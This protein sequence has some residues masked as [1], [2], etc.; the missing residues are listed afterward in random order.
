[1]KKRITISVDDKLM[2]FLRNKQAKMTL[3]LNQSISFSNVVTL[4]LHKAIK[5][6]K[7]NNSKLDSVFIRQN[8]MHF[9]VDKI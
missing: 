6:E 4:L 5:V 9:Q 7:M 1:M 2:W 8:G 3:E